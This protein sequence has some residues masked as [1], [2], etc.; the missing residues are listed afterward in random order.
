MRKVLVI[1]CRKREPLANI[2]PVIILQYF[3]IFFVG[4]C[5]NPIPD[6]DKLYRQISVSFIV[7]IR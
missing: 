5:F 7:R 6:Y 2:F 3:W 1:I 4:N